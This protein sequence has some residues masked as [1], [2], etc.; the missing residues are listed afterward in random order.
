[1]RQPQYRVRRKVRGSMRRWVWRH[2][3]WGGWRNLHRLRRRHVQTYVGQC[4]GLYSMRQPQYR[5]QRKVRGS[6]RRWVW[7]HRR[8]SGWRN[9]HR[10]RRRHVQT[11]G[12]QRTGLYPMRERQRRVWRRVCRS[13]ASRLMHRLDV[14]SNRRGYRMHRVCSEHHWVRTHVR[15]NLRHRV[16]RGGRR[17]CCGRRHLCGM[18]GQQL[19]MHCRQQTLHP[20][21]STQ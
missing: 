6:M 7:R 1:M 15:R 2:R 4:I 20:L 13:T 11:Y 8:W 21:C 17:S 9:L 18:H 12:G 16:R 19:Q 5:V 3:R 14:Q 10:M